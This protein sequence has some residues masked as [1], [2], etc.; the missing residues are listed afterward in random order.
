MLKRIPIW[1]LAS[2]VLAVTL[3]VWALV[4]ASKFH[5]IAVYLF[6]VFA[7]GA[8]KLGLQQLLILFLLLNMT[9]FLVS[10]WRIAVDFVVRG[11]R[12]FGS[13]QKV[14]W[15]LVAA[16]SAQ[17]VISFPLFLLGTRYEASKGA[18]QFLPYAGVS[19]AAS[20]ALLLTLHMWFERR[21]YLRSDTSAVPAP[22]Q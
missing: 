6:W 21:R 15:W 1:E 12:C 18:R 19:F 17:I 14:W 9:A 3:I 5:L 11:P 20:F 16:G 22:V 8:G 4:S 13:I 7:M 2:R 10:M